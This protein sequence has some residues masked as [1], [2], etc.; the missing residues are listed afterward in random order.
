MC[1]ILPDNSMLI[2]LYASKGYYACENSAKAAW[3]DAPFSKEASRQPGC[4]ADAEVSSGKSYIAVLSKRDDDVN[5]YD[6]V[7]NG[8]ERQR[9]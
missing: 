2:K 1:S 7:Y 8:D 4:Y 9:Y 6:E 5:V 3:Y